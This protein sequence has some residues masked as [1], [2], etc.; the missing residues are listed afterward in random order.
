MK[1]TL[2]ILALL[3]ITPAIALAAWSDPTGT[4]PANNAYEPL[5]VSGSAQS[6][7]GGLLLNTSGAAN[8]LIVQYGNTGIGVVSPA[9]KLD[10]NGS[11]GATAYYYT[12]D[13][14]LKKNI[15]PLKDSLSKIQKLN[16]VTFTWK[17]SNEDSF[18]LVAQDVEKVYPEL[19]NTNSKTGFKSVQYGNLVA[20]LIE[21][22]K[23]QQKQ[24]DSLRSEIEK[25]KSGQ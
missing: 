7:S 10:V 5:N 20:P 2:Y 6:K 23:E 21:A 17:D 14:R 8:G 16:G 3:V 9:Y 19:V 4:P 15:T 12:S 1:K 11:V 25:L 22:I 18:G 13:K 24:I